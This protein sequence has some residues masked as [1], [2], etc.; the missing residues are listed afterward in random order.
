MP[1]STDPDRLRHEHGLGIPLIRVLADEAEITS[2][3]GG[4]TVRL[5]VYHSPR[6]HQPD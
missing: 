4:T 1:E 6:P 2:S 3:E 5:V